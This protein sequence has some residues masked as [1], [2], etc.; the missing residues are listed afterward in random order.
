MSEQE[1]QKPDG[2]SEDEQFIM[3]CDLSDDTKSLLTEYL[4]QKGNNKGKMRKSGKYIIKAVEIIND[5]MD[6]DELV[7]EEGDGKKAPYTLFKDKLAEAFNYANF[8]D[9]DVANKDQTIVEQQMVAKFGIALIHAGKFNTD[10][11]YTTK[12]RYAKANTEFHKTFK[13]YPQSK[14]GKMD[15]RD[16]YGILNSKEFWNFGLRLVCD[17]FIEAGQIKKEE[18]ASLINNRNFEK[19]IPELKKIKDKGADI[20]RYNPQRVTKELNEFFDSTMS[21]LQNPTDKEIVDW[22]IEKTFVERTTSHTKLQEEYAIM[23]SIEID[24]ATKT[25]IRLASLSTY[26][27]FHTLIINFDE[28][29][30]YFPCRELFIKRSKELFQV[31]FD[32]GYITKS[33]YN[34]LLLNAFTKNPT[35]TFYS[36]MADYFMNDNALSYQ[37]AIPCCKGVYNM[38][39]PFDPFTDIQSFADRANFTKLLVNAFIKSENNSGRPFQLQELVAILAILNRKKDADGNFYPDW[40]M[41]L[42]EHFDAL[43]GEKMKDRDE[44][45]DKFDKQFN[46]IL[47]SKDEVEEDYE[48]LIKNLECYAREGAGYTD[49]MIDHLRL[50]FFSKKAKTCFAPGFDMSCVQPADTDSGYNRFCRGDFELAVAVTSGGK[51]TYLCNITTNNWMKGH[52]CYLFSGEDTESTIIPRIFQSMGIFDNKDE[53]ESIE[54]N[55]NRHKYWQAMLFNGYYNGAGQLCMATHKSPTPTGFLG[56]D[57]SGVIKHATEFNDVKNLDSV[58]VDYVKSFERIVSGKPD[59]GL[60]VYRKL[61]GLAKDYGMSVYSAQ[62]LKKEKNSKESPIVEI[63]DIAGDSNGLFGT[64]RIIV[65]TDSNDRIKDDTFGNIAF[66]TMIS[67]K[68]KDGTENTAK[69]VI[70]AKDMQLF[71]DCGNDVVIGDTGDMGGDNGDADDEEVPF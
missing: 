63:R 18:G 28:L 5:V 51:T 26:D 24:E 14:G 54:N 29:D 31:I 17:V 66:N 60:E 53:S 49:E 2:I 36:Y 4:I 12:N 61:I 69:S 57:V 16:Y 21:L 3:D 43:K 11:K 71:V 9:F 1:K 45:R 65:I 27:N 33:K 48:M 10:P 50:I 55:V 38:E 30:A 41:F 42:Y 34:A 62:Q 39:N 22:T 52:N 15:K 20:K 7:I 68:T 47:N 25:K 58:Q 6:S 13:N 35:K 37:Y 67:I 46:G 59:H 19:A 44:L 70:F 56:D 64:R 32:K 40:D 23:K 8:T